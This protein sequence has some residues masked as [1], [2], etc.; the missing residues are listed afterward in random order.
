MSNQQSYHLR[1][2][3]QRSNV[4]INR[5]DAPA[6]LLVERVADVARLIYCV[7]LAHEHDGE[8]ELVS[9]V[10]RVQDL[11]ARDRHSGRA[12]GLAL[13]FDVAGL[14]LLAVNSGRV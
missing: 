13:D 6:G 14:G 8:Q 1:T 4:E 5:R 11:V 12:P 9:L 2:L 10:E 3:K 7:V